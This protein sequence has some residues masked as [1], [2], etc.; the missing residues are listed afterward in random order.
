MIMKDGTL[1]F[2]FLWLAQ[3]LDTDHKGY[4][5]V[6]PGTV[7]TSIDGVFAAGDVQDPHWRQA[8]TAAGGDNTDWKVGFIVTRLIYG[9]VI[10]IIVVWPSGT[11]CMAA[12]SVERYLTESG[13]L[14]EIHLPV[15][16]EL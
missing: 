14:Q 7:A 12:L 15:G 16:S 4:L 8:I 11:G 3:G 1:T 9:I 6:K 13:L 10:S 2:I 5:K